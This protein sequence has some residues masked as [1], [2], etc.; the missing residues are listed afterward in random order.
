MPQ[1]IDALLDADLVK[2]I[3]GS[4]SVVRG[5]QVDSLVAEQTY[6]VG[7]LDPLTWVQ[8]FLAGNPLLLLGLG[9]LAALLIAVLLFLSLRPVPAPVSRIRTEPRY[10]HP[11]APAT[12]GQPARR[13]PARPGGACAADCPFS[14][15][16]AG[17]TDRGAFGLAGQPR[18]RPPPRGQRAR[19]P[20]SA[21]CG[22]AAPGR[23]GTASPNA[24][25]RKTAASSTS[26]SRRC[27]APR[28]ASPTPCSSPWWPTSPSASSACGAGA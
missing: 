9:I 18:P 10:M 8:W 5:K 13:R 25:P 16:T 6:Y 4:T 22:A 21:S 17:A 20:A 24:S 23:C 2:E 14:D 1:I 15:P 11:Q 26:T 27:T 28:K 12:P 19:R 7:R 3:Q